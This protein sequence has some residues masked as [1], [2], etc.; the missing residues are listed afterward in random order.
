MRLRYWYASAKYAVLAWLDRLTGWRWVNDACWDA[1]EEKHAD[2]L[3]AEVKRLQA[4][5]REHRATSGA[6][7]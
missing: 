5:L 1:V 7:T 4:E 2:A 3:D 6:K